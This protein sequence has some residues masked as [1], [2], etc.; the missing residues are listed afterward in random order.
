M[1]KLTLT[2]LTSLTNEV[3][4]VAAINN[5]SGDIETAL[6]NTLSRDGTSP[7]SMAA[8]LDMDSNKILNLGAPTAG[9]DAATKTYVDNRYAVTNPTAFP[10]ALEDFASALGTMKVLVDNG[11]V[12]GNVTIDQILAAD[13]ISTVFYNLAGTSDP[14]VNDDTADGYEAG[15][16]WFN[17]V[18]GL[19]WRC[20][21][22]TAGAA[23]WSPVD[24]HPGSKATCYYPVYTGIHVAAAFPSTTSAYFY[25][26]TV[27]SKITTTTIHFHA[28]SAAAD[29]HLQ[30]AIYKNSVAND[31]SYG[32]PN[33]API[34]VDNTGGLVPNGAT[35]DDVAC[36]FS[37]SV[38]LWPNVVYWIGVA[39]DNTPTLLGFSS[40]DY[41]ME[42]MI[43][44]SSL[45]GNT[46]LTA[47]SIAHTAASAM[48][49]LSSSSVFTDHAS[50]GIPIARFAG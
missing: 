12:N 43:G 32:R 37:S 35:N 5:N 4:A 26:F 36:T 19:F 39:C 9:S 46:A 29:A 44:R 23:V 3:A 50:T 28:T 49:T 48:P 18:T 24:G 27:P 13:G 6:E 34:A 42:R 17:G 45:N 2:D 11:S 33:G 7:N 30:C 40:T 22:A 20:L 21:S 41:T 16:L 8:D 10:N 25:P 14:T 1:A 47:L 15:S 31:A 38:V